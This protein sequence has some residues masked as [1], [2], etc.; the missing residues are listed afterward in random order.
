VSRD[1]QRRKAI[2]SNPQYED[3]FEERNI[4]QVEQ[5]RTKKLKYPSI[6]QINN[7]TLHKYYWQSGDDYYKVSEKFYGDAKF[8]YII[9]QFNQI[10]FEGDI[11][12]GDTLMI[13]RPLARV[14]QVIS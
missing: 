4:K 8:W 2:N 1:S 7:L 5:Y 13:P 12:V 10:P 9:A 11:Q 3:L 6:K 14:L